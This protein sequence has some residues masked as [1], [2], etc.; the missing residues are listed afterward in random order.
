MVGIAALVLAVAVTAL[1]LA[2][3]GEGGDRLDASE[4]RDEETRRTTT[5]AQDEDAAEASPSSAPEP[6]EPMAAPPTL[7]NDEPVVSASPRASSGSGP[8]APVDPAR[9]LY[10]EHV[11]MFWSGELPDTSND[12]VQ[13]AK[14][15]LE[16]RYGVATQ[17]VYGDDYRSLKDGTVAV[18]F[19]GPFSGVRDAAQW[20]WDQGERDV[21]RCI[22]VGLNDD[23]EPTDRNGT[24]RMYINEL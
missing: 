12:E 9:P 19:V 8:A 17:V 18:V 10:G 16:A 20:C 24:G 13:R 5:T 7:P 21:N 14:A 11:A 6:D 15:E 2:L 22:G 1:V 4:G 3:G 23:F